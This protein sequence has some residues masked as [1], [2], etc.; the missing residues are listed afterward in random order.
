[1]S[2]AAE[3]E[4]SDKL[5]ALKLGFFLATWGQQ[6]SGRIIADAHKHEVSGEML[7]AS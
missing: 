4:I 3:I 7:A 2:T 5:D 1:M 6:Q